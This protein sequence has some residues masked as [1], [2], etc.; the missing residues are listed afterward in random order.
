M[1]TL[2]EQAKTVRLHAYAPYS[3]FK[4]G[5]ALKTKN[6]KVFVGCNVE[7]A[8]FAL[9]QCAEAN[10]IA[11]MI[12]AGEKNIKELLLVADTELCP[13]CGA[14]RQIIA[15]FSQA[16]TLIHLANLQGI[17]KTLTIEELLPFSFSAQQ[18]NKN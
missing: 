15:E 2:F 11:S 13:P 1:N 4:V 16:K 3:Q 14:C 17:Q 9:T 8:S 7:N 10:A 6:E 5:C 12:A 18:L